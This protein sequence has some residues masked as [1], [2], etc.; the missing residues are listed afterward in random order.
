MTKLED[1][2]NQ[3]ILISPLDW[4]FGHTTR[5]IPIIKRLLSQNNIITFAGNKTQ[6]NFIRKEFPTIKTVF[7]NGYNITLDSKKSTYLQITSQLFTIT[8]AIKSEFAWVKNFVT[9]NKVDLII[10]DNRYG[11]RHHVIPS[12]FISHQLNLQV[13][14]FKA[15]V[16]KKLSA[17]INKFNTCWIPDNPS[18]NLSGELSNPSQLTIPFQHIGIQ[19]RFTK[20]NDLIKYDYLVIISGPKPENFNFLTQI[21]NLFLNTSKSIAVASPIESL[22]KNQNIDYFITPSTQDLNRLI[23]ASTHIISRSGYTTLMDIYKLE[24]KGLFIPTK[25]QFEQEYLAKTIKQN[26][27]TFIN[28]LSVINT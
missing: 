7:I 18:I 24:K 5:C 2:H 10:S 16:N 25:G 1:I 6:T 17:F 3:Q 9:N 14:K 12:I 4:G 13:P 15:L 11:F 27:F 23:N 26:N 28:D 8:K 19:S 22:S 21:N 20:T